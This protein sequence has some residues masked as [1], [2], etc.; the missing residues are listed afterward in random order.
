MGIGRRPDKRTSHALPRL[1]FGSRYGRRKLQTDKDEWIPARRALELVANSY[2]NSGRPRYLA[3]CDAADAIIRRLKAGILRATADYFVFSEY[4]DEIPGIQE[5]INKEYWLKLFNFDPYNEQIDWIS[6]DFI[7]STTGSPTEFRF[8][9]HGVCFERR[10]LPAVD[11]QALCGDNQLEA[12]ISKGG[13]P[14]A[15]WWP[16]FPPTKRQ[17]KRCTRTTNETARHWKRH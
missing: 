17:P 13:R 12:K 9:A 16:A 11:S 3:E 2:E 7:L 1:T 4:W 8:E 6:G 10:G 14:P 15:N 5:E